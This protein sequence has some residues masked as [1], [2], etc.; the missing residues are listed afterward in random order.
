MRKDS[1]YFFPSGTQCRGCTVQVAG[2]LVLRT[3]F[4]ERPDALVFGGACGV[5]LTSI[6]SSGL[7]TEA[8]TASAL[9]ACLEL[10]GS[11]RPV[12]ALT[13]EGRT[14]DI[15]F[16]D[17]SGAF[18]D[19]YEY[20]HIVFDNEAYSA[21]GGHRTSTTERGAATNIHPE[22]KPSIKKH[23][24]MMMIF[25][26]AAYCATATPAYPED[27]MEKIRRGLRHMPSFVQI[28]GPCVTSWGLDPD[29]SIRVSRMAVET[30]LFP[31]WEYCD[32]LF[33][34]TVRVEKHRPVVDYLSL[35]RR[36]RKLNEALLSEFDEQVGRVNRF[37][38]ALEVGLGKAM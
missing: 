1:A 23:P 9:K 8:S 34:R 14:V 27:L 11:D 33:R 38:D 5:G 37:C 32:G 2:K 20:M 18:S 17:L 30:G 22:G 25:N 3:I 12:V 13:G 7:G 6:K 29:L 36:F 28:L 4:E 35:Q 31:L 24:A 21:S 19:G 26:N 10:R 15:G 16:A